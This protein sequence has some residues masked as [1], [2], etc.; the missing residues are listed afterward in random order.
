[1]TEFNPADAPAALHPVAGV[2]DS[3]PGR[4]LRY[5]AIVVTVTILAYSNLIYSSSMDNEF[6]NWDDESL[7]VRNTTIRSLSLDNLVTIFTPV[8]G[9]TYQPIR[10]LSYALDYQLWQL[11][12]VGYQLTNVLL[13]TAAAVLL[14]LFLWRVTSTFFPHASA[15]AVGMTAL[16]TALVFAVHPVNVEAVAWVSGR[17]YCLLGFFTCAG[18]YC[19]AESGRGG[20]R[21]WWFM[22][23]SL[24]ATVL[25]ILSSPLGVMLPGLYVL[26]DVTGAVKLEK[27]A[28]VRRRLAMYGGLFVVCAILAPILWRALVGGGAEGGASKGHYQDRPVYT[29]LTM[30]RVLAD[31]FRNLV[32]PLWLN[33]R[34]VDRMTTSILDA[35]VLAAIVAIGALL[36]GLCRAGSR[37]RR[38][39][40]FCAGW[41]AIGWFPASNIIPIGIK[42]A[43]RYI[44]IAAIGVF[45]ALALVLHR[46]GDAASAGSGRRT[47]AIRMGQVG[48]VAVLLGFTSQRVKIWENSVTLWSDSVAKE[49][50]NFMAHAS[51]GSAL[52][53]RGAY[54]QAIFH[55]TESLR[56]NPTHANTYFNLGNVYLAVGDSAAAIL[57]FE[58]TL[59]LDSAYIDARINLGIVRARA[60]DLEGAAHEFTLARNAAPENVAARRN[61]ENV[62]RIMAQSP[63]YTPEPPREREE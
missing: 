62:L 14:L 37:Q 48:V 12:P 6:T 47:T 57:C 63:Q 44:Y 26:C 53:R 3:K 8:S 33:C 2:S 39:L 10:V 16:F 30:L 34:Y 7:V 31:Y 54:D 60:G 55:L 56:I 28:A 19:Y 40:T 43:D 22:F 5:A 24:A 35:K 58:S 32:V 11:N 29:L 51:L 27:K 20:G 46:Y 18:L 36:F 1:M 50:G 45:Y 4:K 59:A 52:G 23:A 17:K 61:H 13:H 42:M 15:S 21:R 38:T 49:R 9:W 25:A 41:F